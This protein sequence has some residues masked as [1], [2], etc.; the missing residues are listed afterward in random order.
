M[1]SQLAGMPRWSALE[2]LE[3]SALWAYLE[4]L[5]PVTDGS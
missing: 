2:D 3:I 5:E 1:Y 4:S